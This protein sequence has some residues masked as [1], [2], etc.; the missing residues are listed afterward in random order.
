MAK[1][2]MHERLV[3]LVRERPA[4][5]LEAL[6]CVAAIPLPKHDELVVAT[7]AT[8]P[9][10]ESALRADAVLVLRRGGH[11]VAAVVVEVQS[12]PDR[13][14]R[15]A[16]PAYVASAHRDHRCPVALL[17]V[18][19]SRRVERWARRV[20]AFGWP[21]VALVPLVAGPG[22]LPR[23]ASPDEA[24]RRPWLTLLAAV[25][26]ARGPDATDLIPPALAAID[27]LPGDEGGLGAF[28]CDMLGA[29]FVGAAKQ[30]WESAM[31]KNYE[32]QSPVLRKIVRESEARG[33]ALG[34]ARGVALGEARGVALGEARGRAEAVLT[35]LEVR[36]IQ[37]PPEVVERVLQ[38][39]D[40]PT[41]ERLVRRAAVIA[42]ADE[43]F[44]EA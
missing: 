41:L 32:F 42:R 9:T 11:N 39:H 36:G 14:K 1:S 23:I 17:V 22:S 20:P 25:A 30:H 16:W 29:A 27:E 13:D 34:E 38:C 44:A 4:L 31:L 35:F 8:S 6:H 10:R 26:H 19:T 33:V 3:D 24:R 18:T 40:L 15:Y 12:R 37:V 5:A 2:T 7:E 43:L 21:A 28:L